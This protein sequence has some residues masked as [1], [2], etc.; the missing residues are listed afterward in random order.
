MNANK[1]ILGK[2]E[3]CGEYE[4]L[5]FENSK[6]ICDQCSRIVE[7]N[8]SIAGSSITQIGLDDQ[9]LWE[10]EETRII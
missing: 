4:V 10:L 3:N 5:I 1:T 7:D 9:V 8:I 6:Y 2:C